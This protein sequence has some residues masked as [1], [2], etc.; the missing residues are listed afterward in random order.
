[1]IIIVPDVI[2][3]LNEIEANLNKLSIKKLLKSGNE[4][5]LELA[6]PKFLIKSSVTLNEPLRN[7]NYFKCILVYLHIMYLIFLRN[8]SDFLF[9]F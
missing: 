1:M 2:E 8:I 5:Y 7:V 4:H 6:L 3:G 9:L